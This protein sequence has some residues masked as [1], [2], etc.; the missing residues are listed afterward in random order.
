M[1]KT[2]KQDFDKLKRQ[3]E[4][5]GKLHS[6]LVECN[7]ELNATQVVVLIVKAELLSTSKAP[8]REAKHLKKLVDNQQEKKIKHEL[9]IQNMH[10]KVKQ[11]TLEETC[12][13]TSNPSAS[14]TPKKSLA[15]GLDDKKELATHNALLKKQQKENDDARTALKKD[16]KKKEMQ[17]NL[18]FAAGGMLQNTFNM[19]GGMWQSTFVAEISVCLAFNITSISILI[20]L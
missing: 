15:M 8:A 19:N 1:K 14:K 13:R 10:V 12:E 3:Y 18:G 2:H 20:L 17:L 6:N 5:L 7:S 9:D 4:T 16:L 11:L